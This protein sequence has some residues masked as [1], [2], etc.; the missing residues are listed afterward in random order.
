MHGTV[1]HSSLKTFF[2]AVAAIL[3]LFIGFFLIALMFGLIQSADSTP[4]SLF[5]SEIQPNAKGE[6]KVLSKSAPVILKLNI[7]GVI[8]T[9]LLSSN[10]VNN[11]LIETREGSLKNDRVKAILLSINS[12]GGTV[13]DADGIYRHLLEYK[14]RYNVP[15]YAYVDGLCASGGMY[16]ASAADKIYASDVSLIGSVGVIAGPFLNASELMKTVG[17]HAL[18]LSAG[19]GKDNLDPLRPWKPDEEKPMQDIITNF[20]GSFVDIVTKA[21]PNLSKEKLITEYGA[22]IFPAVTAQQYGYI[23]VAGANY[24]L[25]L[26]DLVNKIGIED[27]Y[28]QVISLSQSPWASI[29]NSKTSPL[30]GKVVHTLDLP[31]DLKPELMNQYLYLYRP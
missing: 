3:G 6:R 5:S 12:P 9:E 15:V 27:D 26:N 2:M 14:K 31:Y 19:I 21:R 25:A 30:F 23:D 24:E 8:G 22:H 1:L 29:F 20:Y 10:L 7:N 18:T 28:Y 16:I 17:L 11:L 4:P 13:S